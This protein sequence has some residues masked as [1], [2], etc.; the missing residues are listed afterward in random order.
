MNKQGADQ[1]VLIRRLICVH[2][3]HKWNKQPFIYE[4]QFGKC[5]HRILRSDCASASAQSDQSLRWS[6]YGWP[7]VQPFFMRKIKTLI[8]LCACVDLSESSLCAPFAGYRLICDLVYS[9][10]CLKRTLKN[11]QNKDLNV[12]LKLNEGRKYF[13]MLSIL[14]YFWPPLS[15]N[16]VLKPILVFF[17]SDRL[18]QVLLYW[19]L[20]YLG[21]MT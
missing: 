9:K 3:V 5:A 6:L 2:F 21:K 16:R 18:R 4:V 14:Q 10:T 13:R 19:V 1:I 20:L 8:R 11:R 7:R 12:K 15:N 17:L